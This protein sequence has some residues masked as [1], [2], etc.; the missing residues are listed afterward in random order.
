MGRKLTEDNLEDLKK[1]Y[2]VLSNQELTEKYNCSYS[3][4][5]RFCK[6]HG[7]KSRRANGRSSTKK[8]T[9]PYEHLEEFLQD[10]E[11]NVLPIEE[12]E[13]KFFCAIDNPIFYCKAL[14]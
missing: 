2:G 5:E 8:Y 3:T 6:S 10:W 13:K 9:Y 12:L 14:W 11:D 4:I 1:D 7:F